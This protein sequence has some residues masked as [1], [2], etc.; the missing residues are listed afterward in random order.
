MLCN[1]QGRLLGRL[2][3]LPG[4]TNRVRGFSFY[5]GGSNEFRDAVR[6]GANEV[7]VSYSVM[8]QDGWQWVKGGKLPGGCAI[9]TFIRVHLTDRYTVGGIGSSSYGCS[10]GRQEDREECFDLRL[11]WREKGAGELYSYLPMNNQNDKAQLAVPPQSFGHGD[12]GY[13]VGR[14]SFTFPAGQYVAIAQ[15]I[16]LNDPRAFNGEVQVWANGEKVIDLQGISMRSSEDSVVQGMHFQTFFGG[17]SRD[18]AS[19][20]NQ[21]AWFADISGAVING[22]CS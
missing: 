11:M 20:V 22:E 17:S 21:T 14:G 3:T 8:F 10:G 5:S 2:F 9:F 1:S 12:F 6:A 16:R 19:P 13:S 18:W 15:R 4:R 7:M